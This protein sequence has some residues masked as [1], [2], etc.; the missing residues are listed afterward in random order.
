L[1]VGDLHPDVNE[2]TLQDKFGAV[3][4]VANIHVCR[5]SVTRKSLGYAYVNFF[6]HADAQKAMDQLNYTAIRGRACRIMWNRK[7]RGKVVGSPKAN[8]FVK[9]L[10]SSI[11][12]RS[13]FE[14][15]NIFGNILSCKV[16]VDPGGISRGYGFVQYESEDAAK[17]A[18]ERVNGME[19]AGKAVFVGPFMKR[20]QVGQTEGG[21]AS[22][23]IRNVPGDWNDQKVAEVFGEFGKI[24]STLVLD[25]W[26]TGKRYGY[27]NYEDGDSA[28]K[29]IDALHGK[30]VRTDEEKAA[31]EEQEQA[32]ASG[33]DKSTG[34][35]PCESEDAKDTAAEVPQVEDKPTEDKP[36]GEGD[37]A[38]KSPDKDDPDKKTPQYC[39]SVSRTKTRS[40]RDADMNKRR[41]AARAPVRE[42]VKLHVR[43]LPK[44]MTDDGLKKR[45]M[46]F[47][48][49]TDIKAVLDRDSGECKGYGFVRYATMDEAN[50]AIAALHMKESFPGQPPMN[51]ALSTG[52]KG[53]ERGRGGGKGDGKGKGGKGFKGGG[54]GGG[55]GLA[56]GAYPP[57][58]PYPPQFG[59]PPRPMYHPAGV[60]P[61][62]AYGHPGAPMPPPLGYP[63]PRPGMPLPPPV[64]GSPY[65]GQLPVP[66]QPPAIGAPGA[67]LTVAGLATLPRPMRK[68]LLGERLYPR[69]AAMDPQLGGK[70]TGML[71]EMDDGEI[72][73]MLQSVDALTKKVAEAREVLSRMAA[74]PTTAPAAK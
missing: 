52:G 65:P 39:L 19:I 2:Y 37:S 70:I 59:V 69:I 54:F 40:E 33:K 32:K 36:A 41:D 10:D 29:A 6:A 67:P 62:G 28:T 13:L 43:N 15:F 64:A 38:E 12:S 26:R 7:D 56:P 30:D 22:V 17:Q 1:Y 58:A 50:A 74:T 68:Q 11:D 23:Y 63:Y 47:G 24:S 72:L 44:D 3:G 18:I 9:N 4:P 73:T 20:D 71:L 57:A 49:L 60:P 53:A 25:E 48:T 34:E 21:D 14:T 35:K 5:D 66:G 42:G 61:M 46:E 8:I 45:F 51:V 31:M 55:C 16:S 27:V